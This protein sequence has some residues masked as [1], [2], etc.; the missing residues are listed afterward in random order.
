M[1]V[2][3]GDPPQ[4]MSNTYPERLPNV[5]EI[6]EVS[7]EEAEYELNRWQVGRVGRHE[8]NPYVFPES[9]VLDFIGT[10][11]LVVIHYQDMVGANEWS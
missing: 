7:F 6:L 5:D 8:Q 9:P 4:A 1:G 11:D 3:G 10:M 2:L